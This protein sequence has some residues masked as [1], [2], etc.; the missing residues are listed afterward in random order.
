M[1]NIIS[2]FSRT[3]PKLR[4]TGQQVADKVLTTDQKIQKLKQ[5]QETIK[6]TREQ[7]ES[8]QKTLKPTKLIFPI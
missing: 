6:H 1:S 3:I 4:L 2:M 8:M 7:L 5:T